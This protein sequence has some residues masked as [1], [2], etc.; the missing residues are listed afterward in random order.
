ATVSVEKML[1]QTTVL[2]PLTVIS[3]PVIDPAANMSDKVKKIFQKSK[4]QSIQLNLAWCKQMTEPRVALREKLTFF[5]HDHF[6]C[7]A[8]IPWLAQQQNN[9]IRTHALGSFADLLMSVSKDPA[10]IQFLN[11]QQN[12]KTSP[13]E[14]FAREVMELFTLGRGQYSED[15]VKEAAR[16]F[17]GW[18]FDPRT[19]EFLFRPQV[20]DDGMKSFRGSKGNFTGE[21]I[22]EQLLNDRQTARFVT[23]KVWAYF[24]SNEVRDEEIIRTLAAQ[25]YQSNYNIQQLIQSI[26]LSEWF[27]EPRFAGNRIKSPIELMIGLQL[28]TQGTFVMPATATFLQ[29]AMGQILFFPPNVGGWPQGREWIDS[30][31]LTFRLSLPGILLRGDSTDFQSK[32]DGDINNL[33][34][35]YGHARFAFQVDWDQLAQHWMADRSATTLQRIEDFLLAQPTTPANRKLIEK[36]TASAAN[37]REWMQRAYIGYMSLPEYQL[38]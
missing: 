34:N 21:E 9:T 29:R 2:E 37:D 5:W 36:Y 28:Q 17:T 16:A 19:G 31:S 27:Y 26:A 13:N 12:K 3:K 33:T 1:E 6:A 4:E 15:D 25:F 22:I 8:R 10:M 38:C 7:R 24:V 23:E 18:A 11:N 30:S 32:D 20:H 14:N 35:N